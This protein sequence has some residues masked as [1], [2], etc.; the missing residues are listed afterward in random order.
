MNKKPLTLELVQNVV[1]KSYRKLVDQETVDTINKLTEDPD[2]GEEFKNSIITHTSILDGTNNWSLKQY[3]DGVKFY[4]LTAAGLSQVDAYCKVF[5]ERLQ[6]RLDRGQSKVD[7]NGEASRFNSTD[8][9]NKIRQQALVP[10]HLV[11]QGTTQLAIN[12]LTDLMLKGRSEV[13]R[14]SAATAL[15]K[16]LRPPEAQQVDL[17]IG[18]NDDARA[19]QER[20]NQQLLEIAENQRRLL[21][22]GVPLAEIQKIHVQKEDHIEAELDE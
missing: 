15:L 18:L 16:E 10:L 13:A 17:K 19:A 11:N 4:S 14:V 22:A 6:S 8:L 3:V 21:Q 12:T 20:Q 9:V 5:P 1:P 7:M 2:Y